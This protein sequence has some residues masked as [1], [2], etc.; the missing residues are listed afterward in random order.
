MVLVQKSLSYSGDDLQK[1]PP[2]GPQ[3]TFLLKILAF[4]ILFYYA[5]GAQPYIGFGW[6][7]QLFASFF[8]IVMG[9][10]V[11][12]YTARIANEEKQGKINLTNEKFKKV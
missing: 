1:W 3:K 4:C 11:H 6:W 2:K 9:S 7:L 10:S 8:I 5:D 12:P